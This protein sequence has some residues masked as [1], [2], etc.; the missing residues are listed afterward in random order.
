MHN[1]YFTICLK[2]ITKHNLFFCLNGMTKPYILITEMT[3]HTDKRVDSPNYLK[4]IIFYESWHECVQLLSWKTLRQKD[5]SPKYH[6]NTFSK[7]DTDWEVD[8]E[9]EGAQFYPLFFPHQIVPK[10]VGSLRD[11]W[12]IRLHH[13]F[14]SQYLEK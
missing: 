1:A 5:V 3:K 13:R 10:A 2:S 14:C 11:V 7:V 9:W 4:P 6:A 8:T 12:E